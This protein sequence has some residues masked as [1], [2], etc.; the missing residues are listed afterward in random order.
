MI[1]LAHI[2]SDALLETFQ[3]AEV[4]NPFKLFQLCPAYFQEEA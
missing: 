3:Q 2:L 4:T 1:G